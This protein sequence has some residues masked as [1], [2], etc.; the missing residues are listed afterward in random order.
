MAIMS[1]VVAKTLI[2][3]VQAGAA[4]HWFRGSTGTPLT[5]PAIRAVD[6][7]E[8][9]AVLHTIFHTNLF[10]YQ[11]L[12]QN[13]VPTLL[14]GAISGTTET[15]I[16]KVGIAASA[17]I[18]AAVDPARSALLA[19]LSRLWAAGR[20]AEVR[21]LV[22]KASMISTPVVLGMFALIALL[23]GPILDL[24]SGGNPV[25]GAGTVLL[26]GMLGQVTYASAFWR[27]AVLFAAH[28]SKIVGIVA[29]I[30][31]AVMLA[32]LIPG[33]VAFGAV[34]AAAG[35]LLGRVFTDGTLTVMAIRLLRGEA[36]E[37]RRVAGR[38]TPVTAPGG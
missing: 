35:V 14:L 22:T 6:R 19:R 24:L 37:H 23:H 16:Y 5:Q 7:T 33:V 9:R 25:D 21:R 32:A 34:G 8:R 38:S 4:A 27:T 17:A 11:R 18:G 3:C 30:G 28:K 29:S 20:R 13:Q 10:S 2:S 36:D 12:V 26:L 15:A 1:L 31:A